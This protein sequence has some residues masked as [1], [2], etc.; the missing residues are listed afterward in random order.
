MLFK[1]A[2]GISAN[3]RDVAGAFQMGPKKRNSEEPLL[4][5]ETKLQGKRGHD[6]RDIKIAGVVRYQHVTFFRIKL[7][8]S[9]CN[10]PDACHRQQNTRPAARDSMLSPSGGIEKR[11][12]Q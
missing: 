12:H 10:H 9:F 7:L 1:E 11:C 5:E 4:G 6:H 8:D 3:H 2:R